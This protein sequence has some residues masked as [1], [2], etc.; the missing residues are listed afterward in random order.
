MLL[1]RTGGANRNGSMNDFVSTETGSVEIVVTE[2]ADRI[3]SLTIGVGG[4]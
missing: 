3:L 1:A 4:T 2:N